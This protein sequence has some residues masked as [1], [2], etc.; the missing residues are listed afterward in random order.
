MN[1][2]GSK[3]TKWIVASVLGVALLGGGVA[4]AM[5]SKPTAIDWYGFQIRIEERGLEETQ[6][7]LRWVVAKDDQLLS[8]GLA[9]SREIAVDSAKSAI[10]ALRE[11]APTA[12][13][14][15]A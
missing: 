12:L 8:S 10:E 4:L 13:G 2:D 9:E 5:S 15:V 14:G 1:E 11:A 7:P 3:K 6:K